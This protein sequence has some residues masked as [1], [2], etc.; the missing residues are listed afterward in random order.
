MVLFEYFWHGQGPSV[1]K[2]LVADSG[3]E[4]RFGTEWEQDMGYYRT[5]HGK[6]YHASTGC[7][8]IAGKEIIPCNGTDGLAPCED[9]ISRGSGVGGGSPVGVAGGTRVMLGNGEEFLV[10]GDAGGEFHYESRYDRRVLVPN[11]CHLEAINGEVSVVDDVLEELKAQRRAMEEETDWQELA[12]YDMNWRPPERDAF[13]MS[14]APERPHLV[15]DRKAEIAAIDRQISARQFEIA[16]RAEGIR[17]QVAREMRESEA[18][19]LSPTGNTGAMASSG[20]IASVVSENPVGVAERGNAVM[21]AGQDMRPRQAPKPSPK[22]G[23]SFV[24]ASRSMLSRWKKEQRDKERLIAHNRKVREEAVARLPKSKRSEAMREMRRSEAE[25][26]ESRFRAAQ[27][28][29]GKIIRSYAGGRRD[30]Q[31]MASGVARSITSQMD[32]LSEST[33]R[34]AFPS[35]SKTELDM[36]GIWERLGHEQ[37]EALAHQLADRMEQEGYAS[38]LRMEAIRA[39]ATMEAERKGWGSPRIRPG[40]SYDSLAWNVDAESPFVCAMKIAG[41][42]SKQRQAAMRE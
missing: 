41:K 26:E 23:L 10:S 4:S 6:H 39:S 5:P 17:S 2:W 32:S 20:D 27:E 9:C 19:T 7:K 16:S 13:D 12:D 25:L 22:L 33:M 40:H 8:H 28:S 35:L 37:R 11:G 1:A 30:E 18:T 24:L 15:A 3:I 36:D 42:R 34:D 21:G 29:K 14:P 38:H 31:G